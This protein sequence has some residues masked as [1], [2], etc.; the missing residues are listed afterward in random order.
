MPVLNEVEKVAKLLATTGWDTTPTC[1]SF[2]TPV[3]D[4][5]DVFTVA[6]HQMTSLGPTVAGEHPGKTTIKPRS[7]LNRL[8]LQVLE[9]GLSWGCVPG[10]TFLPTRSEWNFT[11]FGVVGALVGKRWWI[12]HPSKFTIPAHERILSVRY[13][14]SEGVP[15]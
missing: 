10:A 2:H 3:D 13:P 4:C 7:L 5:A 12:V 1:A 15:L 11:V 14:R 9:T 6:E 8:Y